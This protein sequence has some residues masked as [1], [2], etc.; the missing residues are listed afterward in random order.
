M[1]ERVARASVPAPGVDQSIMVMIVMVRI[2][3]QLHGVKCDLYFDQVDVGQ[4]VEPVAA[5]CQRALPRERQKVQQRHV[6]EL[7]KSN[8]AHMK[9][10]PV[11]CVQ[12]QQFMLFKCTR[13]VFR[14]ASSWR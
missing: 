12:S 10:T 13:T 2:Q 6:R 5:P 9:D 1:C 4:T 11:S 3:E 14:N 7:L 8:T